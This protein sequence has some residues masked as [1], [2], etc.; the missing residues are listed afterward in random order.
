MLGIRNLEIMIYSIKR[1]LLRCLILSTLAAWGCGSIATKYPE[2]DFHIM[3]IS[4]THISNDESKIERLNVLADKINRG[5]FPGVAFVVNTGDVVS[6]V[7]KSYNKDNPQPQESRLFKA[8][9]AFNRFQIPYYWVMGNHDYKIDSDR[10]S[11][12]PYEYDEILF[13][14]KIW[15]QMTGFNPFYS[16]AYSGWKFIVFGKW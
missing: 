5:E 10:D 14:E 13:M 6:S 2:G 9:T 16:F 12:A 3:V 8:L 4:D 7:Y 1:Y 15:K 11:D